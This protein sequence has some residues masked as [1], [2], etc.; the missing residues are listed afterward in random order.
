MTARTVLGTC[1][2]DCPDSCGWVVTVEGSQA[3]KLRGNAEH[4]YSQGELCP[5][6]NSFLDR[7]YH[8]DR[9]LYPM[10]RVGPKGEGQFERISWDRALELISGRLREVIERHGGEAVLPWWD[11]G[12]QGLIQMSSLDRRFF[13]NLG[14][15]RQ[16]GSICG[17]TARAGLQVTYGSGKSA[18]P[19]DVRFSKFIVLWG[20]NTRLTNRH[21]WPFIEE[22]RAN[23]AQVVVVDPIRTITAGSADWFIQPLPGT[24]VALML[25]MMHVLILNGLVDHEYLRD[26]ALGFDDLAERVAD[27]DPERAA[28]VCGVD[29][30]EIDR[31][32]HAYGTSRPSFI[33]TLI[34][35]EHHERGAMFFRTLACLPVL[36]GA[37]RERGGGLSRSVGVWAE[38]QTDD[39]VFDVPSDTRQ[40][41][42]NHLGRALTDPAVGIRALFVWNGNP[43][44]S[45]PNAAQIR[46]GLAQEDLFTVVS[47]Q[48]LTDTARYADILLP[49]TTEVEHLDV[50]PSWGHLYL[51]WNEPAIAPLGESVP[52]TELWR[53]LARA[54]GMNDPEFDRDDETLVRSALREVDVERLRKQGWVRLNLPDDLRPYSNGG[55]ATASGKAQ[56]RAEALAEIGQDP[57]PSFTPARESPAGDPELA[58]RYPLILLTPKN[59]TR[60]LNS[61][62]SHLHGPK[63]EGP[64]VEIDPADAASRGIEEGDVVAVTN[65]R[66]TLRLP[67]R[68]SGR[69][70]PGV[71]AIPWG[72][73]GKE[74]NVNAL[75]NDTLTDWGGGVAYFDTLVE[76]AA[77]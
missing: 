50:I 4:P 14:A 46:E 12:T 71:V 54:M 7:V 41:S 59:H 1:H 9:L 55:F 49:A 63:E 38:Q 48:F 74:H 15:S 51:G 6:V 5:K 35:A 43:V 47:E 65:D 52:N 29:A 61:S 58:A 69:L 20:T 39:S 28:L 17:N 60:F 68:L 77:L 30:A 57:L 44:V 67:A 2:H 66:A 37:W 76:V 75:T 42:M 53:R 19:M 25:A 31:F 21:L 23:G 70:R 73:W 26:H 72:W 22:A 8:P 45:V 36:T 62:Y 24:D 10:M 3:V 33:R 13:A 16:T 18:D 32:A 64:F 56:L 27:W 40:I 11:A 34:G